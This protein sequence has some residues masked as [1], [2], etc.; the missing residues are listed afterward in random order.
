MATLRRYRLIPGAEV[1]A[2]CDIDPSVLDAVDVPV[3]D[4]DWRVTVARQGVD[5]VYIC[6]DW[7]SHA[8][9][10][11]AALDAGKDVA[12]EVPAVLTEDEGRRLIEAVERS[13]RRYAMME[14][15]C[16]DPFALAT[17]QLVRAGV[18]GEL[19]HLEGAYIHDLRS[20]YAGS[21]YGASSEA[22]AGNPYPTHGIGPVCRLLDLCGDSLDSLVSMSAPGGINITLLRSRHG[23]TVT[24]QYDTV[25]PR[26]YSR[27]QT[28]CGSRGYISKYPLP[29]L[30][31]ESNGV[32]REYR[33]RELDQLLEDYR[34]PWQLRYEAD[35]AAAGVT[36]LMNY[37]MD[38]RLI[39]C[40][41]EGAQPDITVREA[42]LWSLVSPLTHRSVLGGSVP[43]KFPQL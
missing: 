28:V 4:T 3:R 10:S 33:G 34:H 25:T 37:I 26:P 22:C 5:L 13:G 18:L 15:C 8:A 27:M 12:C 24:L 32:T 11:I 29:M 20:Q 23:R 39:D 16:Y 21:W 7:A 31:I 9:I 40:L 42:V 17:E 43:V 14:N 36:N 1:V 38:R 30:S 6:T 35:A 41:R 2:V 19:R